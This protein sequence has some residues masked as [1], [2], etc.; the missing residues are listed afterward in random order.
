MSFFNK[1]VAKDKMTQDQMA[2]ALERVTTATD[3]AAFEHSDMVSQLGA[4]LRGHCW[5]PGGGGGHGGR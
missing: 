1:A 3:I 2:A 4:G 5:L